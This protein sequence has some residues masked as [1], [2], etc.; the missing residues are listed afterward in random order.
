MHILNMVADGLAM[1]A[2]MAWK[3]GWSIVLGFAISAVLQT[4]VSAK[5]L[6]DKLGSNGLRPVA[7]ATLAGAASSS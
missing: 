3:T 1:A 2:G 7:I 6:R 4:I 5:T